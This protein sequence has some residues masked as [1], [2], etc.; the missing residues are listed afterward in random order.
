MPQ[1]KPD[2]ARAINTPTKCFWLNFVACSSSIAVFHLKITFSDVFTLSVGL[3]FEAYLGN[4]HPL[5]KTTYKYNFSR[6]VLQSDYGHLFC[7]IMAR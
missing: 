1:N 5:L 2:K 6:D 3:R 4:R 7:Q